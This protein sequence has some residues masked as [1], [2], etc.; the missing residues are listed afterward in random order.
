MTTPFFPYLFLRTPLMPWKMDFP[1]P[2][3]N[4]S[5]Y[6]STFKQLDMNII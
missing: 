5:V 3:K 2:H 1:L 6:G 4:L